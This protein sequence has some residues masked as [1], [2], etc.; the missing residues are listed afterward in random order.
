MPEVEVKNRCTY[1]VRRGLIRQ[2]WQSTVEGILEVGRLLIE[3]KASLPHGE[4]GDMIDAD[5]PF[6]PRTAQRL[7]V[8]AADDKLSNT[9]H[10]SYLPPAWGTLHAI[11]RLPIDVFEKAIGDG[12]INPEVQRSTITKLMANPVNNDHEPASVTCMI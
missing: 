4:F 1:G 9:T 12:T 2:V 8:I 6:K 10:V 5:L 7:M 3:A 11:T